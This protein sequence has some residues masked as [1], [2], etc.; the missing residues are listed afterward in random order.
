MKI[1]LHSMSTFV[2]GAL[3]LALIV[4]MIAS[5]AHAQ[6]LTDPYG[7]T[8][9]ANAGIGVASHPS[10]KL[11][12]AG[13]SADA[14][15]TTTQ[16]SFGTT[17]ATWWA[18]RLD[19]SNNLHLDR[20][21]PPWAEGVVFNLNGN[22]GIGGAPTQ[23]LEI[24]KAT[25][26]AY[27][28]TRTGGTGYSGWL[29]QTANRHWYAGLQTGSSSFLIRDVT[30]AADRV[31]IDATGNVGIGTTSPLTYVNT[32]A[33]FKPEVS[34][35]NLATYSASGEAVFN[36]ISNRDADGAHIGGLYFTRAGGQYDAHHQVAAIQG[37]QTGTST[38]AGGALWF[39]TKPTGGGSG[40]DNARMVIKQNGRV[41][42][43][44]PTMPDTALLNVAGDIFASTSATIGLA[45]GPLATQRLLV[46]GSA[47]FNG[48]VTGNNSRA[49][50]QDLAEWVPAAEDLAPGTV[51]VL[52]KRSGNTVKAS[53][54]SYDTSVAGV[55]S[56]QPGITLGEEGVS[57]EQI[58]TTGRVRVRVDASKGA[59]AIGDLLVTSDVSGTA[60]KSV[61]IDIGGFSIHRPGTIIGK[62]LEP[63]DRGVRE[64]LVLLSLQ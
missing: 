6:W 15:G 54:E 17:T 61:P 11:R 50:Y 27:G 26:D 40:V 44:D 38:L 20:Q 41:V 31:V 2:I 18:F 5:P 49:N 39:F 62:A 13:S 48:T 51:V 28:R 7:A 57:K 24:I 21:G 19:S 64:I 8:L 23:A 45:G 47:H 36:A 34:G 60:M 58:A 16:L 55:V 9:S 22:V 52:D 43:G 63:L 1:R 56:A 35:T 37:R 12:I 4:V 32:G 3:I 59:I 14:P 46:H 25:T 30:A 53:V 42:I 10:M 33:W 29:S